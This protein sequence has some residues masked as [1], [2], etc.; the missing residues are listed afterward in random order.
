MEDRT[1]FDDR[2]KNKPNP[3]RNEEKKDYK[4]DQI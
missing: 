1:Q 4:N 3:V 2:K